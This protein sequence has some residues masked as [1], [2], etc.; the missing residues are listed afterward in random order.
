MRKVEQ[1]T[2]IVKG[3]DAMIKNLQTQLRALG[4]YAKDFKGYPDT[5]ATDDEA[6]EEAME[7][8]VE[9]A[10]AEVC[11]VTMPCVSF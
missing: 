5:A 2:E 8:A 7:E 3:Q 4:V 9:A 10:V 6:M 11:T 1:L